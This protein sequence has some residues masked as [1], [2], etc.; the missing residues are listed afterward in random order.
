MPELLTDT[1]VSRIE[2][3]LAPDS[4]TL[5]K[6]AAT[7]KAYHDQLL[8]TLKELVAIPSVKDEPAEDAPYGQA[9]KRAL[10]YFV[11]KT[12]S[13]GFTAKNVDNRAAY[14]EFGKG[15]KLVAVACHL[16]V[17]PAGD[18]WSQDPFT[19][20][21][22]DDGFVS[23]RGVADDK[24]PA[25]AVLY[26]MKALMDEGYEPPCR[27]RLIVG[28]DEEN[29]SSCLQYYAK[30]QEIPAS[31]FTADAEFP[32]VFAEKGHLGI[33]LHRKRTQ[34]P[35]DLYLVRAEAGK[36]LNMVPGICKYRLS[37]GK[38]HVVEG[39][40]A[41]AS[42]PQNG[43]NAIQKAFVEIFE[44]C[45]PEANHVIDL[46]HHLF[47]T[48]TDGK[49][50]GVA[51]EDASGALTL[52]VGTLKITEDEVRIG[53]DIRYPITKKGSEIVDKIRE[54]VEKYGFT[55]AECDDSAPLDLG[56][57]SDL[58]TSL[59][60]AYNE[61]CQTKAKAV[62]IGGGTYARALPNICAFGMQF[63]GD[64]DCMHQANEFAEKRR[65]FAAMAI[66]KEALKNL[67]SLYA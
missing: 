46:F 41:H 15:E 35:K 52:N 7:T 58:V 10:D 29:G 49:S 50:L 62:A 3:N 37:D 1:Q 4:K 53:I 25:L 44:A 20:T 5:D 24:G 27:I 8:Q 56:E 32:A 31:G 47:G 65:I 38:D 42:M 63:P 60:K 22:V 51:C 57:D 33:I 6:I 21:E 67:A 54:E 30:T 2:K 16:D 34:S 55:I 45:G 9:C 18:G 28:A 39:K 48:E 61:V 17:V 36:A 43:I 64:P 14:A 66:Y 13:M 26:A 11:E 19:L 23:A 40:Q 12:E 59:M